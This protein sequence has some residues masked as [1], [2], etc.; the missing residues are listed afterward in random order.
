[1]KLKILI[2]DIISFPEQN[3]TSKSHSQWELCKGRRYSRENTA[4]E[5]IVEK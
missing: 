1:M 3:E 2:G 5:G 4:K